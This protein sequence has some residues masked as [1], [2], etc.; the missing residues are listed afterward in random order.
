MDL[1]ARAGLT[2]IQEWLS[3]YCKS[4]MV[5]EGLYPEHDLFIQLKKLKNTPRHLKGEDL[6][7][8]LELEYYEC[9]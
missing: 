9:K 8:H 4:P 7:K 6:I 5:A 3:F 1:A 2:G